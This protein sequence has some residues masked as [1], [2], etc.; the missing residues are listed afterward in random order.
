MSQIPAHFGD[1]MSSRETQV[2]LSGE[3]S[4]LERILLT[5]NGNLQRIIS[6]YFNSKVTVKI[7]QNECVSECMPMKFQR[8]VEL[9]CD[10]KVK[11]V[12]DSSLAVSDPEI[13]SL[14]VN[15]RIGIGQIFRHLNILPEFEL[16]QV[17]K[18]PKGL[19]RVYT[20]SISGMKS[21]I[22]ESFP[23]DVFEAGT[24]MRRS[25]LDLATMNN[26]SSFTGPQ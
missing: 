9:V 25:G 1:I 15:D 20:L 8:S 5:A 10:G 16:L 6:A 11:C 18:T 3:F 21:T 12:A 17:N 19:E 22:K 14:I 7:I 24:D 23:N 26:V 2:T 13:A 4:P